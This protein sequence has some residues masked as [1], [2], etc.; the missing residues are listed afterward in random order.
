MHMAEVPP[1]DRRAAS[2]DDIPRTTS[3]LRDWVRRALTLDPEQQ[4]RLLE[5]IDHV[6]GNQL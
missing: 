5:A 6:L 3:D 2:T 4:A 1:T